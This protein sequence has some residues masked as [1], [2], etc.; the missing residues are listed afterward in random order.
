MFPGDRHCK[1]CPKFIQDHL[2]LHDMKNKL[3]CDVCKW[4]CYDEWQLKL[5]H[6]RRKLNEKNV[7]E[8]G[9]DWKIGWTRCPIG[10]P[11]LSKKREWGEDL[12][13]TTI[14]WHSSW[15][16]KRKKVA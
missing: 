11:R 4:H 7:A 9:I 2:D 10:F 16:F 6:D 12:D 5:H 8:R 15:W 13:V 1:R 3:Y 14:E